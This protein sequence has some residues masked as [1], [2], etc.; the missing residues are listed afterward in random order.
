M[1]GFPAGCFYL[2]VSDLS[3]LL[4][5]LE[6]PHFTVTGEKRLCICFSVNEMTGRHPKSPG[7]GTDAGKMELTDLYIKISGM[8]A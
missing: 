3:E 2:T 8:R 7:N 4:S 6:S 1:A 5:E